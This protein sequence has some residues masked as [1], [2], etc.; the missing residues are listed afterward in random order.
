MLVIF[1]GQQEV[2]FKLFH[3]FSGLR[4]P[5]SYWPSTSS[6]GFRL[7]WADEGFVQSRR[8]LVDRRLRPLTMDK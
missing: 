8:M 6:G 1:C 4:I 7:Q 5:L 2:A 3:Y